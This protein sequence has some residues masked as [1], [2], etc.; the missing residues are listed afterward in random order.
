MGAGGRGGVWGA[1]SAGGCAVSHVG[2]CLLM[3]RGRVGC[4]PGAS[5]RATA[6]K[7]TLTWWSQ[8]LTRGASSRPMAPAVAPGCRSGLPRRVAP[9]CRSGLPRRVLGGRAGLSCC[10]VGRVLG[11][12]AGLSLWLAGSRPSSPPP[13]SCLPPLLSRLGPRPSR[14][15]R[16][17]AARGR[18]IRAQW[19]KSRTGLH[20]S[21]APGPV[22]PEGAPPR[23]EQDRRAGRV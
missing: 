2:F 23:K 4:Q 21:S 10:L 3:A 19:M 13:A 16:T 15:R 9:G 5:F 12:R 8:L 1:A 18:R 17:V 6:A 22:F 14:L 20:W 7:I 11:D